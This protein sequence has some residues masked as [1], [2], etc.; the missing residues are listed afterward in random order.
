MK[1]DVEL[2]ASSQVYRYDRS[3]RLG[4]NGKLVMFAAFVAPNRRGDAWFSVGLASSFPNITESGSEIVADARPCGGG[5]R[6]EGDEQ[7]VAPGCKVFQ[8]PKD[9]SSLAGQVDPSDV[10]E[11]A[12][13]AQDLKDQVLVFRYKG[14]F[15]AINNVSDS[16]YPCAGVLS[17]MALSNAHILRSLCRMALLLIL[18]T[19]ALC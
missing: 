1:H 7:S 11:A 10:E 15:H 8:V 14:K 19:L 2:V 16:F 6:K 12:F 13:T 3:R 5:T 4:T 17:L 9:D 18:R